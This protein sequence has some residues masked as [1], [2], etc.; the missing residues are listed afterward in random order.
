MS[1]S[2]NTYREST[3]TP[4]VLPPLDAPSAVDEANHRIANNL[5]V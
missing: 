5:Q 3:H 1:V 2:I 4:I